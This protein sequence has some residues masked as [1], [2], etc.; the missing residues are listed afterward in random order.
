MEFIITPELH[1]YMQKKKKTHVVVNVAST[2]HSDIEIAE[3]FLR[4]VDDKEAQYLQEKKGFHYRQGDLCGV[5]LPNYV[6]EYDEKVTFGFRK[7]LFMKMLHAD[8]IRV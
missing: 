4:L 1:A 7:V 5:L 3:I 8:G 2:D 6:L